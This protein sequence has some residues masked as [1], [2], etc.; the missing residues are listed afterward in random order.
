MKPL[1]IEGATCR[2]IRYRRFS[3]PGGGDDNVPHV[4]RVFRERHLSAAMVIAADNDKA[5]GRPRG[6]SHSSH[7]HSSY[8]HERLVEHLLLT[9]AEL[10]FVLTFR[11][12][13]NR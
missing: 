1:A 7:F 11:G 5:D 8:S 13:P 12:E 4:A 10:H 3:Q 6:W 2:R 9:P